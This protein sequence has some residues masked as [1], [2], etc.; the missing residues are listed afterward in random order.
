[1]LGA[2]D[3]RPVW[4]VVCF[5]IDRRR[6]GSGRTARPVYRLELAQPAST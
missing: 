3:E 5:Y 6:R 4:S 1:M 2:L